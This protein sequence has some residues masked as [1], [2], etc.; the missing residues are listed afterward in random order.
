MYSRPKPG[1]SEEDLLKLESEY[2]GKVINPNVKSSVV[3]DD[4]VK[5]ESQAHSDNII[6][7]RIDFGGISDG[8]VIQER[9][10][11]DFACSTFAL[12]SPRVKGFPKAFVRDKMIKSSPGGRSIFAKQLHSKRGNA[13]AEGSSVDKPAPQKKHKFGERSTIKENK[14]NEDI[15]KEIHEENIKR[16]ESMSE[17]E[18]KEQQRALLSQ[19]N[20]QL[21]AMLKS[22]HGQPRTCVGSTSGLT[23]IKEGLEECS[24]QRD[25]RMSIDDPNIAVKGADETLKCSS[26]AIKFEHDGGVESSNDSN[27]QLPRDTSETENS[28][29]TPELDLPRDLEE[30]IDKHRWLH[31]DVKESEKLS[32]IGEIPKPI[33]VQPGTG[34]VARFDFEGIILPY[35]AD[36]PVTKALHH[37]GSEPG[38]PGYTLDELLLLSRSAV[39]QQR[40]L[41]LTTLA[42]ILKTAKQGYYDSCLDEP[43]LPLLVERDILTLFR[44]SLDENSHLNLL[45]AALAISQLIV[46]EPDEVCLDL[47]LGLPRSLEQPSLAPK[48]PPKSDD[49][50]KDNIL[51][52][53]D[54][55][56]GALQ[57]DLLPRI[58]YILEVLR[59]PPKAVIS[60]L[61]LLTRIARHSKEVAETVASFPRLM[62]TIFAEFLPSKWHTSANTAKPIDMPSVYGVPLAKAV[63]LMRI[64]ACSSPSFAYTAVSKFG[65]MKS[66]LAYVSIDPSESSLPKG[67]TLTIALEGY[68]LWQILLRYGLTADNFLGFSPLLMNQLRYHECVSMEIEAASKCFDHEFAAALLGL[69]ESSLTV[70]DDGVILNPSSNCLPVGGQIISVILNPLLLCIRKWFTEIIRMS[71]VPKFS[72]L[73]LLGAALSFLST[74]FSRLGN[75]T[76]SG[77]VLELH[78]CVNC[79]L[80]EC[81]VKFMG[82]KNFQ[83]LLQR[84]WSHSSL[85]PTEWTRVVRDPPALPSAGG[86]RWRGEITPILRTTGPL[87]LLLPLANFLLSTLAVK[88]TPSSQIL[89]CFLQNTS[90]LDYVSNIAK[91]KE[92]NCD[93]FGRF[94]IH[95]ISSVVQLAA[96]KEYIKDVE[97]VKYHSVALAVVPLLS[98][99]DVLLKARIFDEVIFEPSFFGNSSQLSAMMDFLSLDNLNKPLPSATGQVIEQP[100]VVLLQEA[101][102][103]LPNIANVMLKQLALKDKKHGPL[104]LAHE[105]PSFLFQTA[106][107][108]HCLG[109]S[110]FYKILADICGTQ[111]ERSSRIENSSPE[112]V[113]LAEACLQWILLMEFLRPTST[114]LVSP[115]LR[116]SYL[117][118]VFL[119]GNDLFLEP[120]VHVHLSVIL[121]E[122]LKQGHEEFDFDERFPGLPPFKDLYVQLL[123]QFDA[124]SYGDALFSH[125]ILM[126]LAQRH[127]LNYRLL[128]WGERADV[129]RACTTAVSQ[130]MVPLEIFLEPPERDPVLLEL[131]LRAL[132]VGIVRDVRSPVPYKIAV[133]HL[134][135][136]L[137]GKLDAAEVI[138]EPVIKSLRSKVEKLPDKHLS[139]LLLKYSGWSAAD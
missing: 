91:S 59:P 49:E 47:L 4:A 92:L 78:D 25:D 65:I 58:R 44:F 113:E 22:R 36:L 24:E 42:A 9:T 104:N 38:R 21:I 53:G 124:V 125:V 8:I 96:R 64:L 114:A 133:H 102:K 136:A 93:W 17:N 106:S 95:F 79:V 71:E 3:Q 120:Q 101:L 109:V 72:A 62:A 30:G 94:E 82:S 39:A 97:Q 57:M 33:P 68:Y 132:A 67:E 84:L 130:L 14:G 7:D 105:F 56:K 103:K 98:S 28:L 87:P 60:L 111:R 54:L 131:Y 134:G 1:E 70:S 31:M 137:Q 85:R 46:D 50:T 81:I 123:L 118:Y 116:F 51:A 18:I 11:D 23:E 45:P 121:R 76:K 74:A 19:L 86:V 99:D 122:V 89:S 40:T 52:R 27:R 20:P 115:T 55:V 48:S 88:S 117:S 34:H 43:L 6:R 107:S 75:G 29:N 15:L 41:A 135:T 66:L 129:L 128:V 108:G 110:W 83:V 2:L 5:L 32:W 12:P 16:L 35:D 127:N 73:K 26:G 126:P 112:K 138:P 37:H 61:E 90:L 139:N 63:K 13:V 119:T 80:E 77:F 100:R 69:L 10:V